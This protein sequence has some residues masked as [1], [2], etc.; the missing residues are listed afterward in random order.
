MA[1]VMGVFKDFHK[2]TVP[3]FFSKDYEKD[4]ANFKVS[5]LQRFDK[6]KGLLGEKDYM[7][8]RL[9]WVD[10]VLAE[11]LQGMT[12]LMPDVIY[13]YPTLIAYIERFWAFPEFQDYFK[14]DRW[15]EH[16]IIPHFCAWKPTT[17]VTLGYWSIRG[18][19]ERLRHLMEYLK[20]P[21]HQVIYDDAKSDPWFK[22]AKPAL[23]KKEPLINLPYLHDKDNIIS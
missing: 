7:A 10:F 21:Y 8:G 2:S 13:N 9:T 22:G 19:G 3:L 20:I 5:A 12:L 15:D 1:A 23:A 4:L 16:S 6:F 17:H 18:L 11:Y 14:S